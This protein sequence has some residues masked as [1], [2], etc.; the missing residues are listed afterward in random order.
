MHDRALELGFA[1]SPVDVSRCADEL[2]IRRATVSAVVR[3][4][5]RDAVS[6]PSRRRGRVRGQFDHGRR[7]DGRFSRTATVAFMCLRVASPRAVT[8]L[9]AQAHELVDFGAAQPFYPGAG[10]GVPHAYILHRQL[11]GPHPLARLQEHPLLK[12]TVQRCLEALIAMLSPRDAR[13]LRCAVADGAVPKQAFVNAYSAFAHAAPWH[14]DVDCLFGTAVIVL[15]RGGPNERFDVA[16]APA[17]PPPR[18]S[19]TLRPETGDAI[20][21][22]R[23]VT[24]RVPRCAGR[25]EAPRCTLVLWF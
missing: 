5:C 8:A 22:L 4:L 13:D 18:P 21:M 12:T 3:Q 24:H 9:A 6:N 17:D 20:V 19:A 10:A 16:M 23:N 15:E 7:P 25:D 11:A 2:H 1:G 14:R